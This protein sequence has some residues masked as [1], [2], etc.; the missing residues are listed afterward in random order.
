MVEEPI[1]QTAPLTI[2]EYSFEEFQDAVESFHGYKAP[3]VIIGGIMTDFAMRQ[4]PPHTLFDAICETTHCLP[5]AVQLLTPCTTGNGW[6]RVFDFGRYALSLFDKYEGKGIRIFI[7]SVKIQAFSEIN[8]WFFKLKPKKEQDSRL[9]MMQIQEAGTAICSMESVTVQ[10]QF[11]KK[12]H[13]NPV[14]VCPLCHEAYPESHGRICRACQGQTP[15][16]IAPEQRVPALN[17]APVGS[18]IGRKTLHDMTEI[19]PGESKGPAF[20]KGHAIGA[21]D[22]CRL[23]QMGRQHIY[24]D[25]GNSLGDQWVHENEAALSF[26]R[27]LAGKGVC[28][29]EPA[30]E[31]KISLKAINDGLLMVDDQVLETFNLVPGVMCAT[32]KGYSVVREGE[33][34]AGTRAIPLYLPRTD[35]ENA[36]KILHERPVFHVLPFRKASVGILVTGTEVFQGL[37]QD[38]FI[39]IIRAKAETF[40]CNIVHTRIVPDEVEAIQNGI[41]EILDA[42]A[43]LLV[44]TAGLSVDP[45]DVTRK[46]LINA[47][48]EDILYGAPIIPGAMTLLAHIGA[49]QVIGVPACALYFKTTSFDLLLPR[50]LAGVSLTRLELSRMGHGAFCLECQTCTFPICPF[51]R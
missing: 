9:L 47:G 33:P 4:L 32:R 30:R 15:Y 27:S 16:G 31:G 8:A 36:V 41:R 18:A 19:I 51:G 3:G 43:D 39:P 20:T 6:L 12:K 5:D 29:T 34:F 23:Q 38:R 24:V 49:V 1:S 40:G 21:G 22:L 46:G 17:I 48:A 26:A 2:G 13:K 14:I 11:L 28:F 7:D 37:I 25:D 35:F 50:L 45:D 10:P 44:T 42:G